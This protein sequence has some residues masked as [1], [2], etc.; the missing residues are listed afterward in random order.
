MHV[1]IAV[2]TF[3]LCGWTLDAPSEDESVV[4]EPAQP[5]AAAP[6]RAPAMQYPMGTSRGGGG[7]KT[8]TDSRTLTRG[9][10]TGGS[11]ILDRSSNGEAVGG[12]RQGP[13]PTLP[14]SPTESAP[15]GAGGLP[16]QLM[17]PT[18]NAP[19]TGTAGTGASSAEQSRRSPLLSPTASMQPR[20]TQTR[21]GSGI[22][23]LGA[24][25]QT[26]HPP[27]MTGA[28]LMTPQTTDKAFSSWRQSSP[29]SPYLLLFQRGGQG[30]DNYASFV[31]PQ[32]EQR[33]LNQQFNRDIY[34]LERNTRG[35]QSMLQ[36]LNQQTRALQ[37]VATPQFYMNYQNFYQGQGY[38]Q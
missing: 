2:G 17:P 20:S 27:A 11:K 21:S 1:A 15:Q 12:Q 26:M 13:S 31:R 38:G 34:G 7:M 19:L 5:A 22:L 24:A 9:G 6:A 32:V 33:F 30:I 23:S 14:L 18:S 37:N 36:Q 10:A 8:R 29:I 25:S 3:L 35:Q 16:G 28:S 4:P